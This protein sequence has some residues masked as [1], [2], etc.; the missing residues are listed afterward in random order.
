MQQMKNQYQVF[1]PCATMTARIRRGMLAY[2][3]RIGPVCG[4]PLLGL[5]Y[6]GILYGGIV[7]RYPLPHDI[8]GI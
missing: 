6:R 1:P 3:L 7:F 8:L 2:N 4:T 5:V